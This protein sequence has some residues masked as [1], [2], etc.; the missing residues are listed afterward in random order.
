MEATMK[1]PILLESTPLSI[2]TLTRLKANGIYSVGELTK[3]SE[4]DLLAIWSLGRK[5]L[6][7]IY[8]LLDS[9]GL[10]LAS[11]P[12][13]LSI[14]T[15]NSEINKVKI[16]FIKAA[17]FYSRG[18]ISNQKLRFMLDKIMTTKIKKVITHSTDGRNFN[19]FLN[20]LQGEPYRVIATKYD[21]SPD[22][23]MQIVRQLWRKIDH[24]IYRAKPKQ[25]RINEI[26]QHLSKHV[27]N[28]NE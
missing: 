22:R 16:F 13:G 17:H 9:F 24:S 20:Y 8:E 28:H 21:L 6:H 19:I 2:R 25:Q 26:S 15:S 1:T 10:A 11:Q 27:V 4:S 7:E 14:P 3:Y 23:I 5:S 12:H 18:Q